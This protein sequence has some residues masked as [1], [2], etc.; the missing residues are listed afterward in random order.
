ML[1]EVWKW[2]SLLQEEVRGLLHTKNMVDYCELPRFWSSWEI[3]WWDDV[4]RNNGGIWQ[5][6]WAI[7]SI[8]KKNHFCIGNTEVYSRFTTLLQKQCSAQISVHILMTD[9]DPDT[10]CLESLNFQTLGQ[11]KMVQIGWYQMMS[12]LWVM[13]TR[14]PKVTCQCSVF[15]M[16]GSCRWQSF[17]SLLTGKVVSI[18]RWLRCQ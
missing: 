17:L 9:P 5:L 1:A 6:R 10:W 2:A 12:L 4:S 8:L 15:C 16:S 13:V 18:P 3:V 7:K 11:L 14:A